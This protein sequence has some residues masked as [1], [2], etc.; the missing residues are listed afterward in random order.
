MQVADPDPDLELGAKP[1]RGGRPVPAVTGGHLPPKCD[2][3]LRRF[4]EYWSSKAA[5][6]RLPGRQHIDPLEIPE[7]LSSIVMMDVVREGDGGVRFRLR[8]VGTEIVALHGRDLTG[9]W[10][11]EAFPSGAAEDVV[12]ANRMVVE[13]RQPHYWRNALHSAGREH[14]RYERLMCPLAADG[15]TVDMLI[16]VFAFEK[17]DTR[18]GSSPTL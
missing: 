6:G 11:D 18:P 10:L 13:S 14:V 17:I 5:E 4:L 15:Q 12:T 16:G 1:G 3:N 9:H 8:L 2:P 7:L